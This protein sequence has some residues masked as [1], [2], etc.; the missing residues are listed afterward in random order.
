M[1]DG[2]GWEVSSVT[3]QAG[4]TPWQSAPLDVT[5]YS[6]AGLLIRFGFSVVNG[7]GPLT[8]GDI[9]LQR[10]FD[11]GEAWRDWPPYEGK[12]LEPGHPEGE[13]VFP[14]AWSQHL[15]DPAQPRT[16]IRAVLSWVDGEHV[17]SVISIEAFATDEVEGELDR[18][19]RGELGEQVQVGGHLVLGRFEDPHAEALRID[20]RLPRLLIERAFLVA[21]EIGHGTGVRVRDVVY[22]VRKIER[23]DDLADLYLRRVAA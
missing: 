10:R 2:N 23:N 5:A 13:I 16:D 21:L 14:P 8:V 19:F 18:F 15:V 22:R 6:P 3:L 12:D 20:G 1:A 7:S 4:G 11:E 17:S 9:R